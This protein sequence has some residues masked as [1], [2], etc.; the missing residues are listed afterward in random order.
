[1]TTVNSNEMPNVN[2]NNK[3]NTIRLA[4]I[5]LASSMDKAKDLEKL[6]AYLADLSARQTD[7]ACLPEMWNCPYVGDRFKDYAEPDGGTVWQAC[8]AM[9]RK[10]KLY[11]CAGT[12]AE[13]GEDGRI[14][15]TAYV[16]D[17]D[18][19]QIHKYR[20]M[21]MF[22][23][24]SPDGKPVFLESASLG[25]GN[26]ISTFET[27]WGK[28]GM[29]VCFDIR[30]PE[31][32]RIMAIEGAKVII[33]PATFSMTT[34]PCHWQISFQARAME[35]QV[36][37]VG[38]APARA[39]ETGY[40]S[41]SHSIVCDPWGRVLTLMDENEGASI[42]ELDLALIEKCRAKLPML[43]ARRSDVYKLSLQD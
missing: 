37:M 18:G 40:T 34:G 35:N 2:A 9:A 30:F 23:I 43:S 27:E 25:A 13:L 12:V 17:R 36:F 11:L 5:Q 24:Y 4:T 33:T 15:N 1:M 28:M 31:L 29:Q 20:K 21:H 8:S 19:N 38:S 3:G 26:T 14:Y 32:S 16:F 22:D 6:D 41:W 7:I 39:P 42:T 10:Y